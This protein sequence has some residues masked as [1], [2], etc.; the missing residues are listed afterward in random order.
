[1]ALKSAQEQCQQALNERNAL[2]TALVKQTRSGTQHMGKLNA[3]GLN[4]F[5]S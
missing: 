2:H 1:M 4:R 5:P 3:G